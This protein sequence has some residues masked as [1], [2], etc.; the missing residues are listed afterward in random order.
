M[1][2]S[3]GSQCMAWPN[4]TDSSFSNSGNPRSWSDFTDS[5][6]VMQVDDLD[7]QPPP[8]LP[9]EHTGGSWSPCPSWSAS[10]WSPCPTWSASKNGS[11]HQQNWEAA[12]LQSSH[13]SQP[14]N[15][16]DEDYNPGTTFSPL[17]PAPKPQ[18][19][20]NASHHI[21]QPTPAIGMSP[22]ILLMC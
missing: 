1:P 12:S 19:E 22:C 18:S 4:F 3:W 11:N 13:S 20:T 10:D 21:T 5:D 9:Q 2:G 16:C 6:P 14:S 7:A 17:L 15:K 8:V